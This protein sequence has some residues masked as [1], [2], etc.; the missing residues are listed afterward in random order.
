LLSRGIVGKYPDIILGRQINHT[1]QN[2]ENR[3]QEDEY[4]YFKKETNVI[5]NNRGRVKLSSQLWGHLFS[6]QLAA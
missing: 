3:K 4:C 1:C 5:A 6:L 2:Q